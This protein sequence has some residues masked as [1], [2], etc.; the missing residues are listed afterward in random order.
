MP[1]GAGKKDQDHDHWPLREAVWAGWGYQ[2]AYDKKMAETKERRD[3][4]RE[5]HEIKR[6]EKQ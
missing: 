5:A 3:A 2:E 4:A 6:K 1:T